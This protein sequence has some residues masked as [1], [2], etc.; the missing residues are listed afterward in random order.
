MKYPYSSEQIHQI[1]SAPK[2]LPEGTSLD[3]EKTGKGGVGRHFESRPQL[4]DGGFVPMRF[5]GKAPRLEDPSTYDVSFLLANQRVRGI[6]FTPVARHN[7]RFKKRIEQGW[8]LNVCDPNAPTT[9]PE[10][11]IHKPFSDFEVTDFLD[12]IH[13]A[14]TEWH[15]DLGD[16]PE[17]SLL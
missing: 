3:L 15:I 12:L 13:K 17:G 1:L 9:S 14:A 8:H 4:R 6:G 5:L 7:L 16:L 11:N 2:H 10:S